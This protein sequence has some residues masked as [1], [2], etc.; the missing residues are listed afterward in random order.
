M[1]YGPPSQYVRRSD[2]RRV[3]DQ[4]TPDDGRLDAVELAER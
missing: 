1:R 2:G 3:A 4:G